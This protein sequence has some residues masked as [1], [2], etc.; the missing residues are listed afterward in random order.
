M[1]EVVYHYDFPDVSAQ[2]R[3]IFDESSVCLDGVVSIQP[4]FNAFQMADHP[5]CVIRHPACEN[6]N[7][8]ILCHLEDELLTV[9][10]DFKLANCVFGVVMH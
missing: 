8:E 3:Q 9:R 4:K 7:F 5:V 2:P 10:P 1:G 6:S